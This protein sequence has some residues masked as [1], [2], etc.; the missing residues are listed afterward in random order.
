ME[1]HHANELA[2]RS[3][4]YF[5]KTLVLLT[6]DRPGF[7]RDHAIAIGRFLQ[8]NGFY[9][10]ECTPRE[11][12]EKNLA[13]LGAMLLLPHAQSVPAEF[14]QAMKH[15]WLQ[16]GQILVLGGPLFCDLIEWEDGAYVKRELSRTVLDAQHSGKTGDIVIEGLVPTHKVFLLQDVL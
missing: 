6:G 14:A 1:L 2:A 4:A 12:M 7:D 9:V 8:E 3:L 16:G 5:D 10:Y 11:F 13:L 15:Y